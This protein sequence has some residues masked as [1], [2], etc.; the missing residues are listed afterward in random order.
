MTEELLETEI[1]TH[2]QSYI[3][4]VSDGDLPV[5]TSQEVGLITR[6]MATQA[7][8]RINII[9]RDLD[10][11]IYNDENFC[12]ALVKLIKSNPKSE[13]NIL[14][15]DPADANQRNHRL[16][17]LYQKMNSFIHIKRIHE[18][19]KDYN[20]AYISIDHTAV[21]FREF[22][23]L[24]EGTANYSNRLFAKQLRMEFSKIWEMSE[25]ETQFRPLNL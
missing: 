11:K 22:A 21:I 20:H 12:T 10:R 19:Y 17:N 6:H 4:G 24:Y 8:Q 14:I 23:D 5:S 25:T 2:L 16:I 3:V 15:H 13:I 7:Y 9:S 1:S 18:E